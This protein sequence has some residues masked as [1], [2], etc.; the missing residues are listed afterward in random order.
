MGIVQDVALVQRTLAQYGVDSWLEDG[1]LLGMLR[2]GEFLPWDSDVDLGVPAAGY[3]MSE[4]RICRDLNA[5][6]FKITAQFFSVR[7]E[8]DRVQESTPIDLALYANVRGELLYTG[9]LF[10]GSSVRGPCRANLVSVFVEFFLMVPSIRAVAALSAISVIW[11]RPCSI[12]KGVRLLIAGCL[13]PLGRLARRAQRSHLLPRIYLMRVNRTYRSQYSR[14]HSDIY[15]LQLFRHRSGI[16][17]SIP[18][19]GERLLSKIYGTEWRTEDRGAT[20]IGENTTRIPCNHW[21]EH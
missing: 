2:E 18:N 17:L 21:K 10:K 6:G 16:V 7:I 4:D 20:W 11:L 19:G 1:S 15:P 12:G 13:W 9:M 5:A 3:L 14:T 8:N